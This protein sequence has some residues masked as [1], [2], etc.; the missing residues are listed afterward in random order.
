MKT[1]CQFLSTCVYMKSHKTKAR[2]NT[3]NLTNADLNENGTGFYFKSIENVISSYDIWGVFV[4]HHSDWL[5]IWQGF[6]MSAISSLQIIFLQVSHFSFHYCASSDYWA[7]FKNWFDFSNLCFSPSTL[8]QCFTS[9]RIIC[10]LIFF[11]NGTMES[12][13]LNITLGTIKE[14]GETSEGGKRQLEFIWV[15]TLYSFAQSRPQSKR[16]SPEVDIVQS[17]IVTCYIHALR[18]DEPQN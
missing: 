7:V 11:C 5:N 2:Y 17:R 18:Q 8:G 14:V 12:F 4:I 10:I 3:F 9:P 13:L 16:H 6:E 1:L 15:T